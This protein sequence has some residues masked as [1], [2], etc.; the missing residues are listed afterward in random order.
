M[1]KLRPATGK[2]LG[3]IR[4]HLRSMALDDTQLL[5]SPF[6]VAEEEGEMLGFA[7]MRRYPAYYELSSLGVLHHHRGKGIGKA[8]L[9]QMLKDL[10]EGDVYIVTDIA[11]FF[12]PLGFEYIKIPPE[13]LVNKAKKLC[14][15]LGRDESVV[16]RYQRKQKNK[17]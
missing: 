6:T 7:R 4:K 14:L 13:L 10:P 12:K 5:E 8:L 2:E 16:M 17:I 1:I 11:G 3:L 15:S 9:G